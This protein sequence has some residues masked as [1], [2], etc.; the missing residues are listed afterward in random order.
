MNGYKV[1]AILLCMCLLSGCIPVSKVLED[2]QL[3]QAIGYDYV[4]EKEFQVTAGATYTPPGIQSKPQNVALTAVGR[5]SKH[6]RQ[7]IQAQSPRPI[8]I[9][10]VGV[11]LFDE[12]LARSGIDDLVDNLQRDPNIGRDISLVVSKGKSNEILSTESEQHESVSQFVIDIVKQNM[13]RTIPSINLHHFLFHYR[14]LGF[15]PF[16]PLIEKKG[17]LIQV[18]GVA[19]FKGDHLAETIDLKEGYIL[20]VLYEK[21][22]KGIIEVDIKEDKQVSIQNLSSNTKFKPEKTAN[23]YTFNVRIKMDGRVMEGGGLDLTQKK[24]I[25]KIEKKSE[26]MLEKEALVLLEKL[27]KLDVD[28]LGIKEELRQEGYKDW[29]KQYGSVHF[30]VDANVHLIQAGIME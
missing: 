1:F 15:D 29:K 11:I 27:Q 7:E 24:N 22:R 16:L 13:E 26:E 8:E 21:I 25:E 17:D 3:I 14:G 10:R 18:S 20:K 12:E 19:L 9:G 4:N 23:G 5:T 2:V 28:P 30:E 6:I